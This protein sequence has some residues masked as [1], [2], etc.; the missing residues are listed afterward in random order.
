VWCI[1]VY[2]Y[3]WNVHVYTVYTHF[4]TVYLFMMQWIC[5]IRHF[6]SIFLKFHCHCVTK[7]CLINSSFGNCVHTVCWRCLLTAGQYIGLSDTM[8]WGMRKFL[9]PYSHK[10]W[11]MGVA[12]SPKSKQQSMEWRHTSLPTNTK[13]KQTTSTWKVNFWDRK[14]VLLVDFVPQGSTINCRC[15]LWH[16]SKIAKLDPE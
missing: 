15:L 11:D 12:Q 10:G 2:I 6:P 4:C 9:K 5:K 3:I 16:N 13:F 14:G 8:Q 7:L 1:Y